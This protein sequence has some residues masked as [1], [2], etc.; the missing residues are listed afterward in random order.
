[1]NTLTQA[2]QRNIYI[3]VTLLLALST[4]LPV[5][6]S[7]Q[8]AAAGSQVTLRSIEMSSSTPGEAGI[9]YKLTFT[10]ASSYNLQG[11][12][13]DF[14][15]DTP[16]I[17]SGTCTGTAGT[18]VPNFTGTTVTNVS[19]ATAGTWTPGTLNSGRTIT[20]SNA[21][22]NNVT[23]ATTV[24]FTFTG[25]N[26]SDTDAGAG[27]AGTFYA[28]I[29]T[30]ANSALPASYTV[31]SPGTYQDYGGVAL[32][33]A[34]AISITATVQ[35]SLTFCVS[36]STITTGC[37]GV[38]SADLILGLGNPPTISYDQIYTKPVYAQV[39]S[40]GVGGTVISIKGSSTGLTNG[41]NT[42]PRINSND[43][44]PGT[45]LVGGSATA[46]GGFG[47]QLATSAPTVGGFGSVQA[48]FGG[49]G[50][51]YGM[52]SGV[53][54]QYGTKLIDSNGGAIVDGDMTLTFGAAAGTG[55][56]AGVYTANYALIATSTY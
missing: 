17:G 39:S 50:A 23:N 24:S 15:D 1:M 10:A 9:T 7:L 8:V 44:A 22:T 36:G 48:P 53:T 42:I 46:T 26:P 35:E 52:H 29:Y 51:D 21:G 13:V 11:L 16:I 6:L 47:A 56:P 49:T 5:L 12:I 30:Y 45:I 19:G 38:T 41:S 18:E 54:G 14:C 31:A 37:G 32:S 2:I 28:R 20:L 43:T 33:T 25:T 3:G 40:N 27:T 34:N 4:M 55:T